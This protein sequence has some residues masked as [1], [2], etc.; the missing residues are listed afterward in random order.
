MVRPPGAAGASLRIALHEVRRLAGAFRRPSTALA[1]AG[2]IALLAMLWPTVL[3]RG[4]MPDRDLYPVSVEPDAPLAGAVAS[5]PRFARIDGGFAAGAVLEVRR[6]GVRALDSDASRAALRELQEALRHWQEARLA[7][8]PDEAAAFPVEVNVL[9]VP[10]RPGFTPPPPPPATNGTATPSPPSLLQSAAGDAATVQEALRPSEVEPPFPVRSLLL[11]FAFLIPMNF[12]AQLHSGSLLAD[13]VRRRALISLTTLHPSRVLVLGRTLPY[14]AA[15][16]LA[17]IVAAVATGTGWQGWLATLPII[18][19]VLSVSLL[20]GL[21]ARSERELTFLLTGSTTM[22]SVFLFLPAIF[23]AV[24]AVAFLSP[25]SVV[26]AS[27]QGD[28][29]PV[30][31]FLYATLPLS[32][33][34]LALAVLGTALYREETLF[35][36]QALRGKVLAALSRRVR[37]AWAAVAAAVLAVPFAFTLE[38][39]VLALAIPVGLGGV[40]PLV[41]VIFLGVA[42]IEERLKLAVAAARRRAGRSALAGGMWAGVGFFLGEKLALLL[43][44]VGFGDLTLGPETLR[45]FGVSTNAALALLPLALHVG[46]SVLAASGLGRRRPWP[47]LAYLGAVAIHSAYNLAAVFL[48]GALE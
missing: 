15:A 8:E 29:V 23:N 45:V 28:L 31:A 44:V 46:C 26:V 17:W 43:A 34:T 5:D 27:M 9:M 3:Q 6:D 2:A 13:R 4:L 18:L 48:L 10:V 22:L 16:L 38:L 32:L 14:L 20:L 11:T 33:C 47:A 42:L 30:G 37:H 39:L 35:S 7:E 1:L 24:P 21:L 19:F 40:V 12:V 25:V 41:A 36:V